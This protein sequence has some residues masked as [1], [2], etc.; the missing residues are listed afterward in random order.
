MS[1]LKFLLRIAQVRPRDLI[2]PIIAGAITLLAALSLTVL[3]GWLITRAWEMPPVLD[4]SVAVTG[5]RVGDFA[6]G[7]PLP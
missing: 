6:S 1:D 4:L 5:A 7:V 3:S 2:S